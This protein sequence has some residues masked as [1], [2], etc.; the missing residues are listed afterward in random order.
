MARTSPL[1]TEK[2]TSLKKPVRD[3]PSTLST[4][5]PMVTVRRGKYW[6]ISRPTI[7]MMIASWLIAL[8]FHVPT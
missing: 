4:S 5:G 1:C 7:A 8:S 2:E 3:S 6:V